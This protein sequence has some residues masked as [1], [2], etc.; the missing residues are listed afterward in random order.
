MHL[1]QNLLKPCQDIA[2]LCKPLSRINI[3]FFCY[4]KIFSDK[5]EIM[6]SNKPDWAK[7][8]Y[9]KK[10]LMNLDY[11]A[12]NNFNLH[13]VIW[14][15]HADNLEILSSARNI[16]NIFHGMTLMLREEDSLELFGFG[17]SKK[18]D[19]SYM[20]LIINNLD[21]L[22]RFC[23]Y[24]KHQASDLIKR[25]GRNKINPLTSNTNIDKNNIVNPIHE[26]IR[27]EFLSDTN[28]N[29]FLRKNDFSLREM[30]CI[31]YLLMGKTARE[32]A[33]NLCVSTR[34]IEARLA[35]M[36]SKLGCKTRSQLVS[37]LIENGFN[38]LI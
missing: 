15:F 36:K 8:F 10:Y 22:E 11:Q 34:T 12:I 9:Q 16:F 29:S 24:F 32:I 13:Y 27:H 6:L 37:Y 14:P 28:L 38:L 3:D 4:H 31:Q 5:S 21:L 1:Y 30:D 23:F 20:N 2:N 35:N 33:N 17:L 7:H 26:G 25:C 18:F 19:M